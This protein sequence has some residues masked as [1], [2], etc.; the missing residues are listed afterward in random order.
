MNSAAPPLTSSEKCHLLDLELTAKSALPQPD[1][2]QVLPWS[3]SPTCE[4][5]RPAFREPGVE[6]T[7]ALI[8]SPGE[9]NH[10]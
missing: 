1:S 10:V 2:A 8:F 9:A 5:G 7:G 4:Q 3:P 6:G